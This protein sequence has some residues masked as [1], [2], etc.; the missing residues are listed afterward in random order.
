MAF[1]ATRT[2]ESVFGNKRIIFGKFTND[3]TSGTIATGLN[4]VDHI[5]CTGATKL[6]ATKGSVAVT[7]AAESTDGFWMAFGSD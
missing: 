1:A 5:S 6:I 2:D 4:K 3:A 7:I